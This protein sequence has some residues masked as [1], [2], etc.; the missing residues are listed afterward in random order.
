MS[1]NLSNLLDTV[2]AVTAVYLALAVI[3]SHVNE[4]FA[5]ILKWRGTTLYQGVL[6]LLVGQA[7]LVRELYAHPLIV[8]S[9][10]DKDGKPVPPPKEGKPVYLP[11]FVDSRNF[12]LA[13]W[14]TLARATHTPKKDAAGNDVKDDA[15]NVVSTFTF[16]SQSVVNDPKTLLTNIS[17]IVNALPGG[18]LQQHLAVL[19]NEAQ[20]DYDRLLRATD[21]WFDRQMDRVSGWYKRHAQ[22]VLFAIA[23]VVVF[24]AGIDTIRITSRLSIDATTRNAIVQN[25]ANAVAAT[26]GPQLAQ[27]VFTATPAP[28]PSGAP[29]PPPSQTPTASQA[30]EKLNHLFATLPLDMY[31]T[32]PLGGYG[33][34]DGADPHPAQTFVL[35]V[36][37]LVLSVF[38]AAL[39]A[40]FWFDLL[41]QLVNVRLAGQKPVDKSRPQ[42]NPPPPSP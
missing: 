33:F 11:S 3:C 14:D 27:Q 13:L 21:A 17:T 12:S 18:P 35:H 32:G 24:G 8:A 2:I 41:G 9:A 28:A 16:R 39:G 22:G 37:G 1:T 38:A 10:N 29:T 40:A 23:I 34:G 15:G 31:L 36:L 6:N 20:G 19:V 7:D 25:A 42:N 5:A 30:A 4:Q 26:A